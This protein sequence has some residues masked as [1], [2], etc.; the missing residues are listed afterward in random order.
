MGCFICGSPWRL[1]PI[2]TSTMPIGGL[3][4]VRLC[5]WY[6]SNGQQHGLVTYT[7]PEREEPAALTAEPPAKEE[8]PWIT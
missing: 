3:G 5:R 4:G 8:K 1:D 7:L 6:C 2:R